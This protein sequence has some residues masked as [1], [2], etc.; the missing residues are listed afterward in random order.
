MNLPLTGIQL[1]F[2]V[3]LTS[4][5]EYDAKHSVKR[6]DSPQWKGGKFEN[7]DPIRNH[8]TG[9]FGQWFKSHPNTVPQNPL[10]TVKPNPQLFRQTPTSG[11][12]VTWLGHS[13]SI[14]EIDGLRFLIDPVWA[15]RASPVQW[16]G[17][18]RWYAPL[19]ELKDLPNIDVILISHN[20]YDHL[21]EVVIR[22]FQN[23]STRFVV[24]LGLA[25]TLQQWGIPLHRISELDWWNATMFGQT[26]IVATPARHASG[27]GLFDHGQSLWCGFAI[28][29]PQHK[30]YYSGDTGP[31]SETE[32]IGQ[33]LGPFDLTMIECGQYDSN[34]PD[35]H[36]TPEQSLALHRNVRGRSMIPMH[37]G[38]F[39]LAFHAWNDPVVRLTKAADTTGVTVL[40]P[41]PGESLEPTQRPKLTP[42]WKEGSYK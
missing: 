37:W 41:Q 28:Q 2:S 27:R 30:V 22:H 9:I 6:E 25:E 34:W 13:T 32:E 24:P 1:L 38:L 7:I 5:A 35:W 11:L 21:D 17:P 33:R 8:F 23:T 36:M 31:M 40:V 29:G 39:K 26:K 14:L 18:K 12:R 3:G 4:A 19:M 20:H 10:P 15:E 16:A 42:W